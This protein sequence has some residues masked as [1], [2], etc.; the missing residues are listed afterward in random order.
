MVH[1]MELLSLM[2]LLLMV[3]KLL[4]FL[5]VN[6][7]VLLLQSMS[8]LVIPQFMLSQVILLNLGIPLNLDITLLQLDRK[9]VV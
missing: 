1:P 3:P 4:L 6:L 8:N 9:S 5:E 2:V 7:M